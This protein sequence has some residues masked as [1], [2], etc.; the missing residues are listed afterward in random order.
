MNR[1]YTAEPTKDQSWCDLAMH[2][3]CTGYTEDERDAE[4][5]TC[6]CHDPQN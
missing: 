1:K 2:E 6:N 3:H 5:C 4:S